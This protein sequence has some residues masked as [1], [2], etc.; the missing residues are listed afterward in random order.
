MKKNTVGI[1]GAAAVAIATL[2]TPAIAI[3]Q[4]YPNKP[5]KVIV[6]W[7]PGGSNDIVA[8]VVMPAMGEEM[9]QKMVIENRGGVT[10]VVGT[11]NFVK[12]AQ[13]DGYT[14]MVHSATHLTN[15]HIYKKLSYDTMTSVAPVI[16]L[17]AQPSALVAHP[18]LPVKNV[19]ELLAL[20]KSKPGQIAYVS[21]GQGSNP[22]MAME[23]LESMA[24]VK[25][26]HQTYRGGPAST[27]ALA[28]GDG[29]VG[30]ATVSTILPYIKDKKVKALGIASLTRSATMPD[31]PTINEAGV[32]GFEL[33][34]WVAIF[35]LAGTPSAVV[36][37]LNAAANKALKRPAVA[38]ALKDSALD[39]IGG[40]TDQMATQMK[41]D[42]ERYG[43]L[44]KM[45]G[46][47]EAQK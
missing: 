44:V 32:T 46:A 8:R 7:P 12:T 23:L 35:A 38:T 41:K 15:G 20:A 26:K 25:L 42:W 27:E 4:A 45:T 14:I 21:A 5:I 13:P 19:K 29:Q 11:E 22:H 24:G 47:D 37:S 34:P 36:Q 16:L 2:A 40:T 3:A 1:L 18:S 39:G 30:F 31:V 10:G 17:A 33:S 6:P 28:T 9:G 43:K